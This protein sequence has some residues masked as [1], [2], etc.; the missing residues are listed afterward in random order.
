[1]AL[2]L[3]DEPGGAPDGEA[4]AA[5]LVQSA[6][7]IAPAARVARRPDFDVPPS[8][9]TDL[10]HLVAASAAQRALPP[11]RRRARSVRPT[12]DR[13]PAVAG[14]VDRTTTAVGFGAVTRHR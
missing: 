10:D 1:M 5:W 3:R 14:E 11:P 6:S 13:G 12:D 8:P 7:P 4:A 2:L 9:H